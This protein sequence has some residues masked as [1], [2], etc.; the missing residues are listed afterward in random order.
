MSIETVEFT[1]RVVGESVKAF[2]LD[3][4]AGFRGW[5]PK[6]QVTEI[7]ETV[8]NGMRYLT[9]EIPEWLAIEKELV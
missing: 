2:L 6:S 1:M 7:E 4:E 5:F 9:F 3:D 8:G